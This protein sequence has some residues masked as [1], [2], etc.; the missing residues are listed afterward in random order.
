MSEPENFLTRWSRRKQDAEQQADEVPA[1]Q[2][3]EERRQDNVEHLA[4]LVWRDASRL[5]PQK[6]NAS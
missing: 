4:P 6:N 2:K 3:L 5:F 1:A